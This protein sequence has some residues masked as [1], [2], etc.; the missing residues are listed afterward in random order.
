MSLLRLRFLL[1]GY[2]EILVK[3]SHIEKFI[4]LSIS[5]GCYLWDIRR[6]QPDLITAKVRLED[7]RALRHIARTTRS[8]LKVRRKI[9]LPFVMGKVRR[10]KMLAVGALVFLAAMYLLSSFI[11]AVDVVSQQEMKLVTKSELIR[12]VEKYGVKP[13]AIKWNLNVDKIEEAVLR[14]FPEVSWV[15][16]EFKGTKASVEIVERVL[17]KKEQLE[18]NPG[19]LIA[20]KAG[21]IKEILVLAGEARAVEGDTVEQ[22]EILISGVILPQAKDQEE[23]AEQ[24]EGEEK[25]SE[26]DDLKPRYVRAKGVIRARVWY[27]AVKEMPLTKQEENRT[28]R[29]HQVVS[30]RFPI[31]TVIIKGSRAVPFTKWDR[32][33]EATRL[34]S[35]RNFTIPVELVK[36]TY[37]ELEQQKVYYSMAEARTLAEAEALRKI[38]AQMPEG[39]GIKAKR[40]VVRSS[41][42]DKVRVTVYVETEEDIARFVPIIVP[43]T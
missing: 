4:N 6:L 1:Q 11:W 15:G 20:R 39:A 17:P 9:G 32:E 10:R 30:L 41:G 23:N 29:T 34:F 5:R 2:T 27:Q 37:Y 13:G 36:T 12:V 8:R 18:K 3:G 35:W 22:G 28:G 25:L 31:K 40:S 14:E 42:E 43:G 19:N 21:V 38:R 7:F 26:E 33:T 16:I 24:L